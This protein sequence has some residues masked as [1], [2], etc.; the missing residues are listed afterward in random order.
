MKPEGQ[1]W[2]DVLK[3]AVFNK[4]PFGIPVIHLSFPGRCWISIV[5]FGR[6]VDPVPA[7]T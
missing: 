7:S 2:V 6:Q 3:P 1:K 4:N 5:E